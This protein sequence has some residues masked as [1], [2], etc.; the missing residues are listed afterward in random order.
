MADL[1]GSGLFV[2]IISM[3]FAVEI[4]RLVIKSGFTIKMPEQVP[5]SV[6]RSFESLIPA[7]LVIIISWFVRVILNIDL[8]KIVNMLFEPLGKFAGD[9][10]LGALIPVFFIVLLWVAGIHGVAVM[11]AVFQPIWFSL[12]DQNIDAKATGEQLPNIVVEPFFQWFVWI[13]GAGAT[14]SLCILMVF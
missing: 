10:L 7:T 4:S 1:G 8:N 5:S 9:S 13:G 14:L 6:A 3:I 2:A 11:G 12:L